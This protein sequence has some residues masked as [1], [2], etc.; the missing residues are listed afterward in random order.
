KTQRHPP[1]TTEWGCK[2]LPKKISG[3]TTQGEQISSNKA[4]LVEDKP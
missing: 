3:G 4:E 1:K 2:A